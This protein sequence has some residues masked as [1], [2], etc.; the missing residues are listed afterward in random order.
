MFNDPLEWARVRRRISFG[1]ADTWNVVYFIP[2]FDFQL[3]A[4]ASKT[5]GICV[6]FVARLYLLKFESQLIGDTR[7]EDRVA[8]GWRATR[9]WR[10]RE[11]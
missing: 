4:V 3:G 9:S 6:E 5:L 11:G 2:S 8:G 1:R 7:F 10:Y